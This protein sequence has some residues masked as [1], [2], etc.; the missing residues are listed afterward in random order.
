MPLSFEDFFFIKRSHS[1]IWDVYSLHKY[2]LGTQRL[3]I[4]S[5]TTRPYPIPSV[6][7][8]RRLCHGDENLFKSS[9]ILRVRWV[10]RVECRK[11]GCGIVG[12]DSGDR[13][14]AIDE[15]YR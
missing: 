7:G 3:W 5:V 14:F 2:A 8:R 10:L 13:R 11:E 9:R 4:S 15:C 6:V 1:F 12:F